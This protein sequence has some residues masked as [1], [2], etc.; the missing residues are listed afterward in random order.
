MFVVTSVNYSYSVTN[1]NQT[2]MD[3]TYFMDVFDKHH[4]R[5]KRPPWALHLHY[6][7]IMVWCNC[8]STSRR[9]AF[10]NLWDGHDVIGVKVEVVS[11][12]STDSLQ[13]WDTSHG[14]IRVGQTMQHHRQDTRQHER[15][16][17]Q[18][19]GQRACKKPWQK[20]VKSFFTTILSQ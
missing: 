14:Q 1:T 6:S 19:L 9:K 16:I 13:S 4:L 15:M 17:G 11:T 3:W 12:L 20:S 18:P 5:P 7:L 8:S 10:L 2:Q